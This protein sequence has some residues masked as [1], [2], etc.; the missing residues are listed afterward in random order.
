MRLQYSHQSQTNKEFQRLTLCMLT[1]N[2]TDVISA[3]TLSYANM[4]PRWVNHVTNSLYFL[5]VIFVGYQ[6]TIYARSCVSRKEKEVCK[7]QADSNKKA[8]Y[9]ALLNK[10]LMV[11]FSLIILTNVRT[12]LIFS[13]GENGEYIHGIIYYSMYILSFYF[14][15]SAG[16]IMFKNYYFDALYNWIDAWKE[17]MIVGIFGY[18]VKAG[19]ENA[20]KIYSS[21]KNKDNNNSDD[22]NNDYSAM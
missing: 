7:E 16:Y 6:F 19:V 10:L 2:V 1:A 11:V 15:A 8:D 14:I 4:M 17:I 9:V 22:N 20:I 5:S 3:V 18:A 12:G 13:M 21:N